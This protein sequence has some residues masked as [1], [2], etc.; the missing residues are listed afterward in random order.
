MRMAQLRYRYRDYLAQVTAAN[1]GDHGIAE[2][3]V[4]QSTTF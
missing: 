3:E 1:L 2:R 4:F